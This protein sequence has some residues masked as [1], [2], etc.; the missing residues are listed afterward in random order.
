MCVLL[1]WHFRQ[2]LDKFLYHQEISK[3][4]LSVPV[5]WYVCFPPPHTGCVFVCMCMCVCVC[6]QYFLVT[7]LKL[8]WSLPIP[9]NVWR[10]F[11]YLLQSVIREYWWESMAK[12]SVF[13]CDIVKCGSGRFGT[14]YHIRYSNKND[15]MM[16]L[17]WFDVVPAMSF[18]HNCTHYGTTVI[19]WQ[20]VPYWYQTFRIQQTTLSMDTLHL[21]N[22]WNVRS[23]S[24]CLNNI[25]IPSQ[26]AISTCQKKWSEYINLTNWCC[27]S[28]K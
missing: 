7:L 11:L 16:C 6:P 24:I 12:K 3:S 2:N 17:P 25:F 8:L 13:P 18:N 23:R 14:K 22:L 15:M 20:L 4:L 27:Q 26:S 19:E 9:Q 21:F 1:C 28:V 5:H 10:T